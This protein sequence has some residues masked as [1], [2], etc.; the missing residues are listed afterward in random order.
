VAVT[1]RDVAQQAGVSIKTVSR[2]VNDQGE[3]S[4]ATRERVLAVIQ[5]LGYRPSKVARALVTQKTDTI[6]LVVG[7]VTYNPF[8]PEVA[9]GV[10]DA[11]QTQGYNVFLCNI[12]EN[13]NHELEVLHSLADHAVDGIIIYPTHFSQDNLKTFADHYRPLIS[14][15]KCIDHP[16]IGLVMLQTCKGA[17]LAV[18]YLVSKG[19]AKI[20]MIA[21]VSP[22][23]LIERVRGFREAMAMHRLNVAKEMIIQAANPTY[24]AGYEAMQEMLAEYPD[25]EAVFTYN[26]LLAM[27]AIRAC[28]EAGR[29]VPDDIAIIGF[30][31][32]EWA[33]KT[34][35]PLT[36][37]RIDKYQLGQVATQQ[38]FK[39]LDNCEE[40]PPPVYV[41]VELIVRESA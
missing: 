19:Y 23:N 38:L 2:V 7:D 41:D 15:N 33:A 5:D 26:D 29:R 3:I 35:P 21:G 4:E 27:G 11:A 30:D 6:G 10:L 37:V 34:T 32:I 17:K 18:D 22:L 24:E 39:M 12:E 36:T 9:R 25:V 14:I 28:R 16:G 13:Q 1:M 20:G 40:T 8:F 31:D